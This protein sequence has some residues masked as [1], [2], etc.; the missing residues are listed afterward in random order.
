[1][2]SRSPRRLRAPQVGWI[3]VG[4]GVTHVA[5]SPL[6]YGSSLR[7]ILSGVVASIDRDP[8]AAQLRGVGFWYL[9]AGLTLL[10]LGGVLIWVQRAI[11]CLPPMFGWSLTI[12]AVLAVLMMPA[13]GFWALLV[14]GGLAVIEAHRTKHVLDR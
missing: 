1:M 11:G 14:P 9:T 6:V 2:A 4:I 5:I 12:L 10:L 3:I 7:S 13:S 8:A